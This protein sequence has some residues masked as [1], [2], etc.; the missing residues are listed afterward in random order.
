MPMP[1]K[2]FLASLNVPR[3]TFDKFERYLVLLRQWQPRI[4]L[5][6]PSTLESAWERHILDSL[7]L[8]P[9]LPT[10]DSQIVDI[11]S[12]AGFPGLALAIAGCSHVHLVESDQR[13]CAFL[14]EVARATGVSPTLHRARAETLIF[15]SVDVFTSRA[16]APLHKLL[17]ILGPRCQK[18]TICLFH[19]GKNYTKELDEVSGWTY[20]LTVHENPMVIDSVILELSHIKH[21]VMS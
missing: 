20:T 18:N 15:P 3:E 11:G 5:V 9:L 21:K 8:L 4:N 14:T 17:N 1:P 19:K 2:D 16:C 10:W 6:A 13:K 7:Q 12:G